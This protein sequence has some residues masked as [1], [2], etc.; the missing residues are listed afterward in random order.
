MNTQFNVFE[1]D[2]NTKGG[3]QDH[4]DMQLIRKNKKTFQLLRT[5]TKKPHALKVYQ[6]ITI[7][8]KSSNF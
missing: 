4:E 8:K 7:I 2:D 3:V 1:E 6:T 5:E